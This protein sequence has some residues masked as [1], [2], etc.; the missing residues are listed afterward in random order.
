MSGPDSGV[1][2]RLKEL[3]LRRGL[4][5]K[6]LSGDR[7]TRNMLSLI[8]SGNASPSVSTLEYLAERLEV[9]VGYFFADGPE[10][11]G[12]LKYAVLDELKARY[13]EGD[14]TS[15]LALCANL[16]ETA[17]DDELCLI[18]AVSAF[19]AAE[20]KA[21]VYRLREADLLLDR[22]EKAAGMSVYCGEG[23]SKSLTFARDLFAS[24][25]TDLIS[26]VLCDLSSVGS[27]IPASAA[28]Y[29]LALRSVRNGSG[30]EFPLTKG[31]HGERH[32]AALLALRGERPR[33]GLKK[34]RELSLDASLPYY[35]Q[36]KVLGDLEN[37]A[38]A[39]GDINLAYS[40]SRRR[41]ELID[42]IRF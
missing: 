35:M 12:F 23:F 28:V 36:Y 40:S 42:R 1:G 3:R 37:A 17:A 21:S 29:F 22:A 4:T 11:G 7:I 9:P 32:I 33:E 10:S 5:Q 31:E 2:V 20:E 18:E 19:R 15:V 38:N 24:A 30:A 27:M 25:A 13:A 14:W 41:L 16:P 8:E 6:E 26:P 39:E 34:L